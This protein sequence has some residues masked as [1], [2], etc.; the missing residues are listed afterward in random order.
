M[1][2]LD[3][4]SNE[5]GKHGGCLLGAGK[6]GYPSA[7][8]GGDNG[9]GEGAS[10][11]DDGTTGWCRV[12]IYRGCQSPDLKGGGATAADGDLVEDLHRRTTLT[13]C[14]MKV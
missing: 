14:N 12:P 6:G 13:C 1:K 5:L 7:D 11:D 9:L 10:S 3:V 4:G 2:D 8:G